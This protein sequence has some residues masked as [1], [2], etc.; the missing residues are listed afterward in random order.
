MEV[1]AGDLRKGIQ[2]QNKYYKIAIMFLQTASNI[3]DGNP[4]T[5]NSIAEISGVIKL[6]TLCNLKRMCQR[7]SLNQR[8]LL[9]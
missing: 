1:S 2:Y 8:L 3:A 4:I 5:E 7:N 6:S 9:V